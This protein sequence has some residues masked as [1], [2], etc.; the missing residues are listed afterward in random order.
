[1]LW[2]QLTF[3]STY[4][5]P[6]RRVFVF[7]INAIR[8]AHVYMYEHEFCNYGFDKQHTPYRSERI[9]YHNFKTMTRKS[10]YNSSLVNSLCKR[11]S[12][13]EYTLCTL[14]ML[15]ISYLLKDEKT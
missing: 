6:T 7:C 13:S 5:S 8:Q 10:S 9:T 2:Y 12:C 4:R 15:I 3:Y 11:F 14:D 1:M